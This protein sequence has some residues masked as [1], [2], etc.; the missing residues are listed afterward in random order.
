MTI[1]KF[2]IVPVTDELI[3][4]LGGPGTRIIIHKKSRLDS[5]T[6][7]NVI[8]KDVMGNWY[9][10]NGKG[11]TFK[12]YIRECEVTYINGKAMVFNFFAVLPK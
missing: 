10:R 6:T 3:E 9:I 5:R 4:S 11:S 2:I 1:I 12:R 8:R 7:S